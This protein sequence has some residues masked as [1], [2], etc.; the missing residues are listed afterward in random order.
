MGDQK[1]GASFNFENHIGVGLKIGE[2][3]RVGLRA[4]HYSNAGIRE[5]DDGIESFSFFYSH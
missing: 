4:I 1:L 3:Q 2:S 5:P